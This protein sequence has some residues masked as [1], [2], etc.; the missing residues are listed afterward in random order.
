MTDLW[1]KTKQNKT[2]EDTWLPI[3]PQIH[4]ELKDEFNLIS[5]S[6]DFVM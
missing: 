2:E 1:S 5:V 3:R 6:Q 4:L